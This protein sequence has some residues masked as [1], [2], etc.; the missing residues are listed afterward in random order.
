[1][2]TRSSPPGTEGSWYG[3]TVEDGH[4]TSLILDSNEVN[5]TAND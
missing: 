2:W 5:G 4:V 1:M 3:V